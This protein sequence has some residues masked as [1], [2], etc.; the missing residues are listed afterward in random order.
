MK[1]EFINV[2]YQGRWWLEGTSTINLRSVEAVPC[3]LF[4]AT[5]LFT[6]SLFFQCQFN[7]LFYT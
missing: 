2:T 4:N 5:S 7:E 3:H 1:E 6:M